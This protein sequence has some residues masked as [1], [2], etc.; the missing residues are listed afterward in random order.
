[1][2]KINNNMVMN[3]LL[4]LLF[5]IMYEYIGFKSLIYFAVFYIIYYGIKLYM[6]RELL[7]YNIRK[8]ET[9][10]YGKPLDKKN[11]KKGELAKKKIK[12]VIN[13]IHV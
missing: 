9:M 12:L 11:W 2:V 3:I 13:G 4:I 8:V 10:I 5:I 6:N 7:L 1:M